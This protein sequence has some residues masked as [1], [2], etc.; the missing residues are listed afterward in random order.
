MAIY[1]IN[2]PRKIYTLLNFSNRQTSEEKLARMI[3]DLCRSTSKWL[4]ANMNVE[5]CMRK[6]KEDIAESLKQEVSCI[7]TAKDKGWGVE[8]VTIDIQDVYIQDTEIFDAMQMQFKTSKLRESELIQLDMK[9]NLELKKL[10]QESELAKHRKQNQL[11]DA[12][13]E[14][15]LKNEQIRLNRETE[16]EEA[17]N[18]AELKNEQIKLNRETKLEEA[19]TDAELQNEQIK[20]NRETELEETKTKAELKNEQIKLNRE[21]QLEEA[22]SKAE[23]LNEE[24]KLTY[25]NE[26]QKFALDHYR[27]EQ[28]E[29]ISQYKLVQEINRE[30]QRLELK[31][32]QAQQEREAK[33]ANL[34]IDIEA[35]QANSEVEIESLRQKTEV[36][37]TASPISLER[38]FIENALPEIANALGKNMNNARFNVIQADKHSGTPFKFVLTELVDILRDR[39]DNL[40]N[41]KKKS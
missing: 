1:R 32:E 27:V 24:I 23:L 36:E 19:K 28:N 9:K 17:K 12:Q 11:E 14:A 3:A 6:R 26:E 16:L 31:A 20:L 10:E 4:V 35:K 41:S 7:V 21:T 18:K 29:N 8:I 30:R 13:Y 40:P 25:Q 5:E 38:S 22:K 37:N 33:K 15:E 2:D 39:M 34:E